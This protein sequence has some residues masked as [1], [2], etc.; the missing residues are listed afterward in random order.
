[1]KGSCGKCHIKIISLQRSEDIDIRVDH[2]RQQDLLS[3][4]SQQFWEMQVN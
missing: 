1:M 3:F 2:I 4:L